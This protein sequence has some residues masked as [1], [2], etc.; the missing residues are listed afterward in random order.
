MR[1]P[2][3]PRPRRKKPRGSTSR[4]LRRDENGVPLWAKVGAGVIALM[5]LIGLILKVVDR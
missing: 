1:D 2:D 4:W 5:A 3:R